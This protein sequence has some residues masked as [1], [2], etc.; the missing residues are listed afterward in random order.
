MKSH[1]AFKLP[2]DDDMCSF[3][4]QLIGIN[5]EMRREYDEKN[6]NIFLTSTATPI[7]NTFH[8]RI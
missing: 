7:K 4:H 5:R 3:L 6:T 2:L 8:H 1:K